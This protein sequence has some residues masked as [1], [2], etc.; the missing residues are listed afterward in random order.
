M[1]IGLIALDVDG[2]LL[3]SSG[4]LRPAVREAVRSAAAR[5]I[6]LALVTGR[7]LAA[8]L[9]VAECLGVP[10]YLLACHGALA[11]DP[12]QRPMW[13]EGI[14]MSAA[15]GALEL[16]RHLGLAPFVYLRRRRRGTPVEE[17]LYPRDADGAAWSWF[18]PDDP[19]LRP[20]D[21]LPRLAVRPIRISAVAPPGPVRRYRQL[22]R[23]RLAGRVGLFAT[24]DL[25]AGNLVVE[26]LPP[27]THKGRA[28]ERL[29]RRL[30]VPRHQVLAVG[31]YHND[32]EMIR[33]AG[34]G[35]AMGNAPE[36]VRAAADW[37]TASNDA[38]G[39]ALAIQRFALAGTAG[40]CP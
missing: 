34:V 17:L 38:D 35:V 19:C 28:L 39:V 16:A 32:T 11:V 31:D 21:G 12:E 7:R 33:W 37:V 14:P 40:G 5:G 6:R 18:P 22:L 10:A 1:R 8:T 9:P 3:D 27:R 30:G 26:V 20:V 13:Q 24:D 15:R 4:T 23:E 25:F 36:P 29:A 2:T